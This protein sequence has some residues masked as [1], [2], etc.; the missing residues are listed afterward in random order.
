MRTKIIIRNR[1]RSGEFTVVLTPIFELL[2]PVKQRSKKV[3]RARIPSGYQVKIV[4]HPSIITFGRTKNEGL[5][6][7]RDAIL[8]HFDKRL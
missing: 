1:S 2:R 4:S 8:C 3:G 5:A 6:M 7:A